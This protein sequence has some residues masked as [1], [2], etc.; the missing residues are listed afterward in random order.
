MT[1]CVDTK[2]WQLKKN[3]ILN[4]YTFNVPLM[5]NTLTDA[6]NREV[7]KNLSGP[8]IKPGVPGSE[9]DRI[10]KEP[11]PRRTGILAN[12]IRTQKISPVLKSI[13]SDPNI[14]PYA[15]HVHNGTRRMKPRPFIKKAIEKVKSEQWQ[16]IKTE[17]MDGVRKLGRKYA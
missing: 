12:S 9:D 13:Y 5:V 11:I 3:S 10:G 15:K 7:S 4:Y 8:Q 14:A 16:M 6:V 2:K 1:K 17:F